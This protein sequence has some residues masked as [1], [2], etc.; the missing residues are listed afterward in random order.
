MVTDK[1]PHTTSLLDV[2]STLKGIFTRRKMMIFPMIFV[3]MIHLGANAYVMGPMGRVLA[4]V[5]TFSYASF[6]ISPDLT[7]PVT[8]F[9]RL[10]YIPLLDKEHQSSC[11]VLLS[12]CYGGS[13]YSYGP[14]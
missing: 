8:F 1:L 10:Q 4:R 6:V 11:Y 13:G 7:Y 12:G 2:N 14:A 3:A 5:H 9:S